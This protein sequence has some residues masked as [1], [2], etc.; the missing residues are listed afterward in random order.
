[1]DI[2]HPYHHINGYHS[3]LPSYTWIPFIN[4]DTIHIHTWILFIHMI[5]RNKYHSSI[6]SYTYIYTYNDKDWPCFRILMYTTQPFIQ[7]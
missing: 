3:A 2:I 1:M 7:E 5:I 4:I 6:P